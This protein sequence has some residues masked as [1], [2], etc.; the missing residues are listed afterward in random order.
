M[1]QKPLDQLR[2]ITDFLNLKFNNSMLSHT[3]ANLTLFR[4]N[5]LSLNEVRNP[6]NDGK[7]GR[8]KK[9]L[10]DADLKL[11]LSVARDTLIE[12]DYEV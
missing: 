7:I 11:F 8:W 6:I 1:V 5:H 9:D 4:S 3:K 10:A 2:K 12:F